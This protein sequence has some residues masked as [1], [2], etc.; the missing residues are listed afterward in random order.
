M[1]VLPEKHAAKFFEKSLSFA[2]FAVCPYSCSR[3]LVQ[4]MVQVIKKNSFLFAS[5]ADKLFGICFM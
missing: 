5:F 2:F 1:V 4:D 3:I